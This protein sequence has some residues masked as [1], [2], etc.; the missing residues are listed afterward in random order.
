MCVDNRHS[1]IKLGSFFEG[2][3]FSFHIEEDKKKI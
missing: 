1:L 3:P 2:S